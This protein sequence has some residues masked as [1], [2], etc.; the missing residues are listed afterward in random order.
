MCGGADPLVSVGEHGR[1]SEQSA[2]REPF[3]AVGEAGRMVTTA[4]A[5]VGRNRSLSRKVAG[6]DLRR[7]GAQQRLGIGL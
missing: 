5:I 1:L 4:P 2:N 7:P 3:A 6:I